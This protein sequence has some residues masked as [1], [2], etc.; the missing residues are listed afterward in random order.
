VCVF[1]SQVYLCIL[2]ILALELQTVVN[3]LLRLKPPVTSALNHWDIL[4][5]HKAPIMALP[6][7][8]GFWRTDFWGWGLVSMVLK[9]YRLQFK[10]SRVPGHPCLHLTSPFLPPP[11]M[12]STRLVSLSELLFVGGGLEGLAT[13]QSCPLQTTLSH[14]QITPSN[15]TAF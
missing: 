14:S 8:Q 5:T 6:N 1:C 7:S 15:A 11:Y 12:A 3:G 4:R 13:E 2:C 9:S 10:Y